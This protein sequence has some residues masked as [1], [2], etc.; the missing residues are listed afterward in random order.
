MAHFLSDAGVD[1]R[2]CGFPATRVTLRVDEAVVPL[3]VLCALACASLDPGPHRVGYRDGTW[4]S[5]AD[6]GELL[7]L[8]DYVPRR[9]SP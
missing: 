9:A 1:G 7:R 6:G 4:Y 5:A 2:Q 3:A 8:R